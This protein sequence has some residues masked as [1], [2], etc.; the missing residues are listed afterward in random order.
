M[1]FLIRLARMC[2]LLAGLLMVAITVMT[3][4][5]VIGRNL[6]GWTIE[7]D[8]EL[9][10]YLAGAAIALF[11]PWCQI[12]RGHIIVDFFTAKASSARQMALDRLGALTMAVVMGLL[13]WRSA[14]GGLSAWSSGAGSMMRGLPEWTVYTA[15][16]PALALTAV[17]ALMQ[18]LRGF[19][20]EV[21]ESEADA[22]SA[23]H[24]GSAA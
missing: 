12:R 3:A 5:S 21:P 24:T 1:V 9:A 4:A 19:G 15:I 18:A 7:G 23:L 20:V 17:I 10:A 16:V 13:A 6:F 14:L 11:L 22:T 2:A 8:F